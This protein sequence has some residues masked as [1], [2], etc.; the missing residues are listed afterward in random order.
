MMSS[1]LG[2]T[3][4]TAAGQ[5][6]TGTI[7]GSVGGQGVW[8]G[9]MV[10]PPAPPAPPVVPPAPPV[11][12]PAPPVV[13][14]V[15]SLPTLTTMTRLTAVIRWSPPGS[16]TVAIVVGT[17]ASWGDGTV[18][19]GVVVGANVP[20]SQAQL[21][22]FLADYAAKSSYGTRPGTLTVT[23][24]IWDTDYTVSAAG[25]I[26]VIGPEYAAGGRGSSITV[27]EPTAIPQAPQPVVIKA[28][29]RVAG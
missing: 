2:D 27:A 9:C 13:P 26:T 7:V 20:V 25:T 15:T 22:A 19:P 12:P 18:Q 23:T 21:A 16:N 28:T 6:P 8:V 11:V 10:A 1:L 24:K 14:P 29:P 5:A 17:P 3:P 4:N